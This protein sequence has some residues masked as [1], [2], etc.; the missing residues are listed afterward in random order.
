MG[1]TLTRPEPDARR[2]LWRLLGNLA[3]ADRLAWLRWCCREAS[4]GQP[5]PVEVAA[6]DGT[7]SAVYRDAVTILGQGRLT[8][9]RAGACLVRLVKNRGG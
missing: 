1:P 7:V 2:D 8:L 4:A 9:D 5:Y 3:P 6:S